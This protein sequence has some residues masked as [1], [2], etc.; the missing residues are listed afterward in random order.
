M[1]SLLACCLLLASGSHPNA[2]TLVREKDLRTR[3]KQTFFVPDPLPKLDAVVHS[4]FE[5]APGVR[6][7][8]VTYRTEFGML[9]PAIV[10]FPN[11]MPHGKIPA[12]VVINGHGGDKYSWYAV[13]SGILYARAGAA[14]LTYDPAGEGERNTGHRSGTREH[15]RW[16]PPEEM[17]RRLAGLMVTDV[18]EGVSW[19]QEQPTVDPNRI[20]AMG[21]SMGSFVLSLACAVDTRLAACVAVGGGNLDGPG[22]YWDSSGKEMCQA[23]PYRSLMFLG[24]RP[25]VIYALQ[26]SHAFT[27]VF[28]GLEDDVVAMPSH[29]QAFFE[30]LKKRTSQLMDNPNRSF[31]FE[32]APVGGHRPWFVTRPVAIWLE[33]HLDFPNWSAGNINNM[34]ESHI[35]QWAELHHIAMEPDYA[36][37]KREGGTQ[38]LGDDLPGV[39]HNE[40]NVLSLKEWE[41]VKSHL[42]YRAWVEQAKARIAQNR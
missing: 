13:Y 2:L 31:E 36:T 18:L 16:I 38:A 10:Y 6:A 37:E 32:F 25:A 14:V 41:R 28:N 21:Y 9:V 27:L 39:T 8:R 11:P 4:Q 35:R 3:I 33:K 22:D 1:I 26:A 29:G 42:I 34:P 15:D 30:D 7:E 19:L 17:A 5:P 23:I 20:G 40:L 24:D 12:L